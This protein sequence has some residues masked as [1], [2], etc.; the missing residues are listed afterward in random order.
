MH[1]PPSAGRLQRHSHEARPGPNL[2]R[3]LATLLVFAGFAAAPLAAAPRVVDF[4]PRSGPPGTAIIVTGLGFGTVTG[5]LGARVGATV[6]NVTTAVDGAVTLTAPAA[7][8]VIEIT[9]AGESSRSLQPFVLTRTVS[10]DFTPP[11]GFN[12]AGYYTGTLSQGSAGNAFTITA[13]V[14]SVGVAWAWRGA[15]DPMF[16]ALVYPGSN[17]IQIDAASTALALVA[18]SPL[19]PKGDPATLDAV[20]DRA[21]GSP[22]LAAVANLIAAASTAGHAY[23]D[24]GRFAALH[25]ALLTRAFTE[26][27]PSALLSASFVPPGAGYVRPLEPENAIAPRRLDHAITQL[28][29]E[30]PLQKL[31]S[32]PAAANPTRLHQNLE[33]WRVNPAWFTDGFDHINR[34]AITDRPWQLDSL[35]YASGFVNAELGSANLDPGEWIGKGVAFLLDGV[36]DTP[37]TDNQFF[38]HRDRPGIYMLNAFS[39]NIWFGTNALDPGRSQSFLISQIDP[40]GQWGAALVTNLLIGAVD[41]ASIFLP[42]L[43]LLGRKELGDIAK[44]VAVELTKS[45]SAYQSAYG[46]L[47][48]DATIQLAKTAA[49]AVAKAASGV[50]AGAAA[51]NKRD[52]FIGGG[53]RLIGQLFDAAGKVSSGLQAVERGASLVT[54]THYAVERTIVTVG[55]PFGPQIL[56]FQP[57]AARSGE[58]LVVTGENLPFSTTGL[59]FSFVTFEATGSPPP[60]S[61]RLVAP[62][63]QSN[64]G[65]Y[66]IQIPSAAQWQAAF[67]PGDHNVFL[68]L[69]N[70][71]SGGETTTQANPFPNYQFTY[72]A[73]PQIT[74]ITPSPARSGDTIEIAGPALDPHV[75]QNTYVEIDGSSAGYVFSSTPGRVYTI[76]PG[77]LSVGAHSLRLIFRDA[78]TFAIVGGSNTLPFT[79]H[80]PYPAPTQS[81][82]RSLLITRRDLSNTPD[83]DLSIHEALALASGTLGRAITVRPQTGEPEG[84]FESDWVSGEDYGPGGAIR[85]SVSVANF[86]TGPTSFTLT[87][88]LPPPAS[89]DS[90]SLTGLVFDGAGTPEG[91]IAYDLRGV[92]GHQLQY[93][94]F[95]N[96]PGE[97]VLLGNGSRFNFLSLV[98][99]ENPDGDGIVLAGDASDNRFYSPVVRDAAGV[100]LRLAG[101]GVTR[102]ILGSATS[103]P[104]GGGP[105]SLLAVYDAV[106]H[107]VLLEAGAHGNFLDLGEIRGCGG[108]GLRV[109]G[110]GTEGNQLGAGAL[111]GFRDIAGNAGHGVHVLDGAT[112]NF[113]TNLAASGNGGDGFRIDGPATRYNTLRSSSAGF[114]FAAEG[115]AAFRAP[116]TGHSLLVQNSPFNTIGTRGTD[117]GLNTTLNHFGGS[118]ASPS[119]LVTGPDAHHNVIDASAF[120]YMDPLHVSDDTPQYLLAPAAGDALRLTGGAHDNLIGSAARVA[121]LVVLAA[122]NGAGIRIDGDGTD[123]NQVLGASIGF[124]RSD[125]ELVGQEVRVGIHVRDTAAD[126]RIGEVGESLGSTHRP[127][128]RFGH[129][130]EAALLLENVQAALTPAGTPLDAN[131]LVN[132]RIGSTVFG[133]GPIVHPE[134]GIHLK[135]AVTGQFVGGPTRAHGN[136]ISRFGYAAIWIQGGVIPDYANRNRITGTW[137]FSAAGTSGSTVNTDPFA[138]PMPSHS[139]LISGGASGQVVGEEWPLY[140]Q[141]GGAWVNTYVDGGADHWLRASWFDLGGRSTIF[142]RNASSCRIGGTDPAHLV[143]LT[144]GASTGEPLTAAIV[145]AGGGGHRVE[146]A[147]IGDRGT[148]DTIWGS[149]S[150]GILVW[151]SANNRIGGPERR[152][153]NTIVRSAADG[154]RILGAGST[155]NLVGN[156]RIGAGAPAS[157]NQGNLG[158]G[159]HFLDGA[160]DNLLGGFQ[161]PWGVPAGPGILSPNTIR[162]NAGDGV[163]VAGAATAG[164]AI[165]ANS[166]HTN[167]GLGIRHSNG[168]NR[169][170][171]P[172]ALVTL[173][174]GRIHGQVASLASTPAGSTIEIFMNPNAPEP[175]GEVSFGRGLVAADGTFSFPYP[176]LPPAGVI[177]A[178]ATHATTG[179]T[180]QFTNA[181]VLPATFGFRL[182]TPAGEGSVTRAWPGG[183]SPF[184]A[185]VLTASSEGAEVEVTALRVRAAASSSG[186]L[187]AIAGVS[188]FEDVDRDGA[189]SAPDRPLSDPL[190]PAAFS[191]PDSIAAIALAGARIHP[192]ES[193]NW[194]LRLHPADGVAPSG[195]VQFEVADANA[196]DEIYWEPLGHAGVAAVFPLRSATLTSGATA[197]PLAAWRAGH[198]LPADGSGD[199]ANAADPDGDG[200]P[201]LAEYALGSSPVDATDAARPAIARL[202]SPTRLTLT[203][204]RLR[205]D[206]T[207]TVEATTD[208]GTVAWSAAGVDQ[209]GAGTPVTA[210]YPLAGPRAFLRLRVTPSAP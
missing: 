19:A 187:A 84:Y 126:N 205:A 98:T 20:L 169:N 74:A 33:L 47:D 138:G 122:P 14:E 56:A 179:D 116:D 115:T 193:R 147:L 94:T 8:G 16:L 77:G 12:A 119:V 165:L 91:T 23:L 198:G 160:H 71:V 46:E 134:I 151:N 107:G 52:G 164:N 132:N 43:P 131:H 79:I 22:E 185:V 89:G 81:N 76:L 209:G 112:G 133:D 53:L 118:L 106:D 31:T 13:P 200:L 128:N 188:L 137:T 153:G 10:G 65:I 67:G 157:P 70:T 25:E 177:T 136:Q 5:N 45:I 127:Y 83:G 68:A 44:S 36:T 7:G 92:S 102:N 58:S 88:P 201:N 166:I 161:T 11:A 24:D 176:F 26:P 113:L 62:I 48:R 108:D 64:G 171:P 148:T 41:V 100:G 63:A 175:E 104:L 158:A 39:G 78:S 152:S 4:S 101:S 95:R 204:A 174:A 21:A 72:R 208:L 135:G 18:L 3:V 69:R 103:P 143:H 2:F 82:T 150:H 60:I 86:A 182:S 202:S 29:A 192:D 206:I 123:R 30:P 40:N 32:S 96:F 114:D 66:R 80:D 139:L 111:P 34:L 167:G 37:S 121:E 163:L 129:I 190:A 109:T 6:A 186:A 1:T 183:A 54:P 55:D 35:P 170:Q 141:F 168:G 87:A 207:Y 145:L 85:D 117:S 105:R 155:G 178:T 130:V 140:N 180:S 146:G 162:D 210:T 42:E 149:R 184:P 144:R 57:S 191:G 99:I 90:V 124:R 197:D 27:E 159:V 110:A 125:I 15:G 49:V 142:V 196:V 203:Y 50:V 181:V 195:S 172:P 28:S 38:L 156:N 51:D 61:A 9:L 194:I 17:N 93:G 59:E 73:P 173:S 199:G 75:L 120:G 97:G 189:W 154:I